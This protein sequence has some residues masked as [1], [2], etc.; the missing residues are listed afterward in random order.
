MLFIC[1]FFQYLTGTKC[2][3]FISGNFSYQATIKLHA[4][5]HH[6]NYFIRTTVGWCTLWLMKYWFVKVTVIHSSQHKCNCPYTAACSAQLM[7][8]LLNGK[9]VCHWMDV[10]LRGFPALARCQGMCIHCSNT[11]L[12]WLLLFL[13]RRAARLVLELWQKAW[14]HWLQITV[15]KEHL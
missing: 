13:S 14:A 10:S 7:H 4:F 11:L 6:R 5:C 15:N 1:L 9:A 3:G 12:W 2:I 8:I